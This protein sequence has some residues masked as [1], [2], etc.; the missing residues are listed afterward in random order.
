MQR[1]NNM[2]LLLFTSRLCSDG[3][4]AVLDGL[5]IYK[6]LLKYFHAQQRDVAFLEVDDKC[7]CYV[8]TFVRTHRHHRSQMQLQFTQKKPVITRRCSL[9]CISPPIR[10]Y[11]QIYGR[12]RTHSNTYTTT[13]RSTNLIISSNSLRSVGGDNYL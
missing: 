6:M 5:L 2:K 8:L 10:V 11:R 3:V 1:I 7:G 9:E 12:T 13:D 4:Q